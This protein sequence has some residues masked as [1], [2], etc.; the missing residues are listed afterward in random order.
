[1]AFA[2]LVENRA[3]EDPASENTELYSF[4]DTVPNAVDTEPDVEE[5][6]AKPSE[7]Y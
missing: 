3:S 1:M 7:P 5:G 6:S 2:V 4:V